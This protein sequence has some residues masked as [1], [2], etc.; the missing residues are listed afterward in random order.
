MKSIPSVV[1]VQRDM[2]E[3][4]VRPTLMTVSPT[5]V[6]MEE[7]VMYVTTLILPLTVLLVLNL[8]SPIGSDQWL[9]VCL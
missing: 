8:L 9:P 3:T 6:K 4:A 1:H 5:L 2:R 7:V